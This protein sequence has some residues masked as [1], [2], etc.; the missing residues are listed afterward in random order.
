MNETL[1]PIIWIYGISGAGKT[2][3]GHQLSDQFRNYCGGG[4]IHLDEFALTEEFPYEA[5]DLAV[6]AA[7]AARHNVVVV[8]HRSML[9]ADR[10]VAGDVCGPSFIP[11]FLD[12]PLGDAEERDPHGLYEEQR[13][14][15]E[16]P[17]GVPAQSIEAPGIKDDDIRVVNDDLE[18]RAVCSLF[19]SI[20]D[21][22]S[23]R[24]YHDHRLAL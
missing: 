3:I 2:A 19:R 24:C 12:T 5:Q 20:L 14:Q 11:V 23:V 16:L 6:I 13:A 8:S 22:I 10:D 17:L 15:E 21:R 1:K 7:E 4:A 9:K 18:S